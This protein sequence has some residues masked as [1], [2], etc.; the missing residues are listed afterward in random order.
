MLAPA[1]IVGGA[2]NAG[3]D[4]N[5][6]QGKFNVNASLMVNQNKGVTTGNTDRT[7]LL[8]TPQT[9]IYQN[10]Y[11]KT[12]GGFI[13]GKLG[14]DYLVSNKTTLSLSAIRVHGEFKP[15]ETIDINTD[16][17]Y[18]TGKVSAYSNRV[19]NSERIFNGGGLVFGMKHLFAKQ[20]EE[21]T[22]DGNLFGGKNSNNALYTTDYYSS[23]TGDL[24]GTDKQKVEG[25]GSDRN[26]VIQTDYTK[27]LNPKTK[28]ETGLR[29]AVRSRK[30]L[31]DNYIYDP[32]AGDY[33]LIPQA[34]SNYTNTDNVYAAYATLSSSIKSFSYKLGLRAESSN[35]SGELLSTGDKFKN[36]YPI[37]FFPSAYLTQKLSESQTLTL[38]YSRRVSRPNFFQLIPYTDYSDKLNITRGNPELVPE[39]T[40]SLELSYLKTFKGNNTLLG[41][42]YYKHSDNLITRY[43][44]QQTNPLTGEP[45]LINTWI[46]ANSSYSARCRIDFPE[47]P[48]E[49]VGHFNQYQYLQFE[50]QYG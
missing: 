14:L 40:Q 2:M 41:S 49:M 36:S 48:Q 12:Q 8:D 15:N 47:L 25:N 31:Q 46:N 30:S 20:G 27:P 19:S 33:V 44:D 1:W 43:I 39:F 22:I 6:R 16:S 32:N 3:G 18:N 29:A 7:N 13:F 5:I 23:V 34:T 45:V 50:D 21:W 9:H 4:F 10:N 37:S 24:T 35:Y 26:L 42:V 11:N 17:L 28:L 38:S